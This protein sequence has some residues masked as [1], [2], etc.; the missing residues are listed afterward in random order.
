MV[1]DRGEALVASSHPTLDAAARIEEGERLLIDRVCAE[2]GWNYGNAVVL[3]QTLAPYV[4]TT[5]LAL[6]ALRSHRAVP[7]ISRSLAYLTERHL[8]ERSG[9]ALA[10]ARIALTMYGAPASGVDE[11]LAD[12]WTRGAFL[13][14]L[15]T[16]ALALYALAG[17]D[18]YDALAS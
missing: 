14:N 5:A 12:A 18:R 15:M 6:V 4:P 17:G 2:G 9:L 8:D 3:G 10:L 16:T 7:A 11:A 1:P 13:G